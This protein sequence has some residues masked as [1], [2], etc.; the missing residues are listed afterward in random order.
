ML[1]IYRDPPLLLNLVDVSCW[2]NTDEGNAMASATPARRREAN[3]A[4]AYQLELP[5]PF[6]FEGE[7]RGWFSSWQILDPGIGDGVAT[8]SVRMYQLL[9]RG[10][11][12]V[13]NYNTACKRDSG[14]FTDR[15]V[16]IQRVANTVAALKN[17]YPT[18]F[19]A[20]ASFGVTWAS[21]GFMD[22]LRGAVEEA[23][24]YAV[25]C[26]V[27][28]TLSAETLGT[29]CLPLARYD[30]ACRRLSIPTTSAFVAHAARRAYQALARYA[31]SEK[32]AP[33]HPDRSSERDRETAEI[34]RFCAGVRGVDTSGFARQMK[35]FLNMV[36]L[37]SPKVKPSATVYQNIV[38]W[39]SQNLR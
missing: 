35:A 19:A 30:R 17:D 37:N 20:V 4:A 8:A 16:D 15:A 10:L 36:E 22:L 21:D 27:G 2:A 11:E 9:L 25:T 6:Q 23:Q 12:L 3:F 31:V 14:T 28:T 18:E 1:N 5:Y 13:H 26:R 34:I 7:G 39:A 29:I 38:D 24:A 32:R 33:W